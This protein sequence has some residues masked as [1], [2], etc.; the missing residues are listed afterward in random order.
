MTFSHAYNNKTLTVD[1]DSLKS[2]LHYTNR[3]LNKVTEALLYYNLQVVDN[4]Q[5]KFE[6][7]R[8][9]V[10]KPTVSIYF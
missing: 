5:V 8:F 9:D 10:T 7:Q 1:I 4:V 3:D 2:I 6:K